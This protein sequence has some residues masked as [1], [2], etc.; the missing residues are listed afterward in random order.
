MSIEIR[1][2][3]THQEY[4]AVEQLQRDAWGLLEVEIVPDHLLITVHKNGGLVLGAFDTPGGGEG[5]QLV[6]F[7]FGFAGLSPDKRLKH[8]SHMTGVKPTHQNQNLGYRLKLAQREHVLAQEVD[9][10]T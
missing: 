1:P 9:L 10:I 4:R 2:I 6:G 8:C 5:E 7:V 3:Q